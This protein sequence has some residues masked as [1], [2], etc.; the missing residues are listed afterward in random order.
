MPSAR[1]RKFIDEFWDLNKEILM[2]RDYRE[3]ISD[4]FPDYLPREW[5]FRNVAHGYDLCKWTVYAFVYYYG[6]ESFIR[7]LWKWYREKHMD[8]II[9]EEYMRY[10]NRIKV[11]ATRV[12]NHIE[13]RIDDVERRIVELKL[14]L[15][16]IRNLVEE[17]VDI[18][19]DLELV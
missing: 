4:T 3:D 16:H 10:I 2:S 19:V 13:K 9:P 17:G 6:N 14:L 8:V 5:I 15:E 11:N 7:E 12:L 1:I 18:E